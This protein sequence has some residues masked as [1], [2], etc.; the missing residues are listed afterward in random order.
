[1]TNRLILNYDFLFIPLQGLRGVVMNGAGMWN[2][3]TGQW[4]SGHG[5]FGAKIRK[6]KTRSSMKGF[7]FPVTVANPL[8]LHRR[9]CPHTYGYNRMPWITW[10]AQCIQS[11][12]DFYQIILLQRIICKCVQTMNKIYVHSWNYIPFI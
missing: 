2:K 9:I 5:S 11:Q 12:L 3:W 1:M 8:M 7:L 6:E 4:A 10:L